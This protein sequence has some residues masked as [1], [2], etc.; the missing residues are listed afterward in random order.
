[1]NLMVFSMDRIS[2]WV[3]YFEAPPLPPFP[4]FLPIP[5]DL[6]YT[7]TTAS[8]AVQCGGGDAVAARHATP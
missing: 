2:I 3:L 7:T 5:D 4:R 6:A 1:M 8:S